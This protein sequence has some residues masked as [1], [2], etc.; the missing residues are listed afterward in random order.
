MVG[1]YRT[2]PCHCLAGR[3]HGRDRID[4]LSLL[5]LARTD[6]RRRVSTRVTCTDATPSRGATVAC[7]VSVPLANML[8]D[9][10]ESRGEY[11]RLDWGVDHLTVHESKLQDH[12]LFLKQFVDACPWQVTHAADFRNMRHINVQELSEILG[13][14]RRATRESLESLRLVNLGD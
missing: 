8:H 12:S 5:P 4:C 3:H 9:L 10:S 11:C 14:I 13:E 7:H 6:L 1:G 2:R